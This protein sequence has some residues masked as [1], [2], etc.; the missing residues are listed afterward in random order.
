MTH[1][2][3]L[4]TLQLKDTA[5]NDSKLSPFQILYVLDHDLCD[6]MAIMGTCL[7][8]S[9]EVLECNLIEV[10]AIIAILCPI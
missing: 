10:I 9:C 8:N 1:C 2:Y 7:S 6:V 5:V 4:F 3:S